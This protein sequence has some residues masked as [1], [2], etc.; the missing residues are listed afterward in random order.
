MFSEGIFGANIAKEFALSNG[1]IEFNTGIEYSFNTSSEN[2][3]ARYELF[4]HEI[5]L[6]DSK[7]A[8][9]KGIFHVEGD[10]EHESGIGFNGKYEMLWSDKERQQNNSGSSYRF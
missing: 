1:K 2:H 5:D 6:E 10:Y 8:S 3:D 9:S 7:I 4:E